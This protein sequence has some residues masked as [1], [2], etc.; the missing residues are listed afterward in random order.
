MPAMH[1]LGGPSNRQRLQDL[2]RPAV[3]CAVASVGIR[4]DAVHVANACVAVTDSRGRPARRTAAGTSKKLATSTR[5]QTANFTN[6]RTVRFSRPASTRYQ[7][8]NVYVQAF[9]E[10]VLSVARRAPQL[11]NPAANIA[12]DAVGAIRHARR[13]RKMGRNEPIPISMCYTLRVRIVRTVSALTVGM[14]AVAIFSMTIASADG[15]VGDAGVVGTA[16]PADRATSCQA[17]ADALCKAHVACVHARLV[18]EVLYPTYADCMKV[19][20]A[21]CT[22]RPSER[23][24]RPS[25]AADDFRRCLTSAQH[26]SANRTACK[27]LSDQEHPAECSEFFAQALARDYQLDAQKLCAPGY[28]RVGGA[29]IV[30]CQTDAECRARCPR[31]AIRRVVAWRRVVHSQAK[32]KHWLLVLSSRRDQSS[33][34]TGRFITCSHQACGQTFFSLSRMQPRAEVLFIRERAHARRAASTCDR[35]AL[36]IKLKT[37]RVTQHDNGTIDVDVAG[38]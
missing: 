17:V 9:G 31:R 29:Y 5:R 20:G 18:D 8:L 37:R 24:L 11:G 14:S 7:M 21:M 36:V 19:E 34:L 38:A 3:D 35:Y 15:T 6:E 13:L 32:R 28:V 12:E 4:Q 1:R 23:P 25:V 22:Q 33:A 30:S 10:R 27:A 26:A 2:A 16:P